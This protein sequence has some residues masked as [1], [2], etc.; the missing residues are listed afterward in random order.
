MML[1]R[2]FIVSSLA[3]ASAA[4][5]PADSSLATGVILTDAALAATSEEWRP[6]ILAEV[7]APRLGRPEDLAGMIA[8]L[9]SDDGAYVNGQSI[10]VDGGGHFT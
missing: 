7:R 2:R 9:F 8:F 6:Q 5:A 10:L 4:A 1:R 3:A